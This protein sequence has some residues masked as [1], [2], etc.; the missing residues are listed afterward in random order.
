MPRLLKIYRQIRTD[1]MKE[2]K[3]YISPTV[4]EWAEIVPEGV[5]CISGNV[6][7]YK[8]EDFEW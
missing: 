7:D 6:V 5:L 1:K 2:T 3:D 8:Q 4:S